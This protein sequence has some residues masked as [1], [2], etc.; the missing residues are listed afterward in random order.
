MKPNKGLWGRGGFPR[1]APCMRA[2]SDEL[3]QGLGITQAMK[4]PDLACGNRATALPMARRGTDVLGVDI[5][6]NL[7]AAARADAEG[8]TN[9]RIIEGD[10]CSPSRPENEKFSRITGMFA[11]RPRDVACQM[12]R[13]KRPGGRIVMGNRIPGDAATAAQMLMAGN[14]PPAPESFLPSSV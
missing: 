1:I 7:V 8:L 5:A 9:I 6:G 14:G 3:A 12:V 10:A 11:P 13:A 4:V 2:S